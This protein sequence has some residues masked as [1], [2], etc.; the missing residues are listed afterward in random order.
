MWSATLL[1]E[2]TSNP[3]PLRYRPAGL[4]GESRAL[5]LGIS[6]QPRSLRG[7]PGEIN[8]DRSGSLGRQLSVNAGV[9]VGLF[10]GTRRGDFTLRSAALRRRCSPSMSPLM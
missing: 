9:Q 5:L 4:R 2:Q 1:G 7:V 8:L 3:Q 6:R 10:D